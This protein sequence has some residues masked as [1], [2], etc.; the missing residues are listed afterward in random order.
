MSAAFTRP[1]VAAGFSVALLGLAE[2]FPRFGGPGRDVPPPAGPAED[3]PYLLSETVGLAMEYAVLSGDRARFD[4]LVGFVA[5]TL[6]SP[7]GLVA[8]RTSDAGPADS[9]ASIDDLVIARALAEGARRWNAPALRERSATIADAV[10]RYEVRDG[11]LVESASWNADGVV[12]SATVQT[13]YLDLAT[14]REFAR[15]VPE[16]QAVH[17]ASLALLH[18]VE[19]E[20]GLFPEG[21]PVGAP[22]PPPGDTIVNG[23]PTL[24]CALHLAEVGEGGDR[25][26][27]FLE[28]QLRENGRIAGRYRLAD[29]APVDGYESVAVY[30]LTARLAATLGK[31]DLARAALL[32]MGDYWHFEPVLVDL[33]RPPRWRETSA[34]D[35]LH[36]MLAYHALVEPA[37]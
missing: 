10:L 22:P 34:F 26:L 20:Q 14:M 35:N 1:V 25:L 11:L 30:A 19:T 9:S 2:L 15:D 21:V 32:R 16:W 36:A 28:R 5:N 27:A 3:G 17:D 12:S 31:P 6:Q 4:H 29:G 18:D 37:P 8:W 33:A 7:N 24:Y 23:I 13:S